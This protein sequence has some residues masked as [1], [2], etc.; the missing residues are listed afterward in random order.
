[1]HNYTKIAAIVAA[2]AVGS[3]ASAR[4][5]STT[6]TIRITGSTAFRSAVYKTLTA[7]SGGYFDSAPTEVLLGN[8]SATHGA[9]ASKSQITF[10][11]TKSAAFPN[12][13]VVVECSYNGSVEGI[14]NVLGYNH[15][16]Q[17]GNDAVG[18]LPLFV[19]ADGTAEA[20]GTKADL[21]FSDV[22][23]NTTTFTAAAK[24]HA[25]E[26]EADSSNFGGQGVGIVSFAFVGST[27]AA[28]LVSNITSDQF[29]TLAANGSLSQGYFTG[30]GTGDTTPVYL[31]GRYPFSGTRITAN[32]VTGLSATTA[33]SLNCPSGA[34]G[35]SGTLL[36]SA[37]TSDVVSGGKTIWAYDS[38]GGGYVSGG[39]IVSLLQG[40]TISGIANSTVILSYLSLGDVDGTTL[41]NN[42]IN[43]NGVQPTRDNIINGTYG[44]FSYEHL[45]GVTGPQ[46]TPTSQPLSVRLFVNGSTVVGGT[47][48]PA[49]AP[50][51][52]NNGFLH[53]LNTQLH[54]N[55]YFVGLD[56]MQ[57]QR[58]NDGGNVAPNY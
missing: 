9:N 41:V 17:T 3:V 50:A 49:P 1:M 4:P 6:T 30:A 37:P 16:N 32:L 15:V 11:G 20:A 44:F 35:V 23:Q 26:F 22:A 19:K 5:P 45:Y 27:N 14:A 13:Q 39:S 28:N 7:T 54:L 8:T 42:L 58:Q 52:N 53:A 24:G 55:N 31:T 18:V 47:I 48:T 33:Q 57:A 12:S 51:I 46:N 38:N 34:D 29:Q 2:L 10:V 40:S 36:P 56:E 25:Y 21:A 43:F